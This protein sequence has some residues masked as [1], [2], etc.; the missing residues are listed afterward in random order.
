MGTH[1]LVSPEQT[2]ARIEP[3]LERCGITRIAELTGLDEDL[4]VPTYTAVRPGGL[5]LQTGNGKGLTKAAARVSAAMEAIEL[6]HAENPDRSRFVRASYD[7]MRAQ[8]RSVCVP[9]RDE[10]DQRFYYS[11]R[12]LIDWV[13]AEELIT[14]TEWWVPA[15]AAFFI[16]P[17]IY[18]TNTNGLASGNHE[19]EA[20][21]HA[22]YELLERDAISSVVQGENLDIR[23]RCRVVDPA[24][25]DDERLQEIIGK[26][27]VAGSQLVLLWVPAQAPVHVFWAFLLNHQPHRAATAFVTGAGA[28]PDLRVAAS[29]AMTEAVQSRLTVIQAARDDVVQRPSF[30]QEELAP[31]A[32]FRYFAALKPNVRWNELCDVGPGGASGFRE[33]R[34]TLTELLENLAEGA[35]ERVLRVSLRW[36][37]TDVSV[38]KVLMPSLRIHRKLF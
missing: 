27:R 28:H 18:Q 16:E 30:S 35:H 21:L 14:G 3:L 15:S 37:E 4:G 24:S 38:V 12:Y 8:G 10:A 17:T 6:W 32:A 25:V 31:G 13:R 11:D 29:R 9:T 22:L 19:V 5:V 1:R 23:G 7:D 34:C 33:L 26:I 36:L 20:T 2:M